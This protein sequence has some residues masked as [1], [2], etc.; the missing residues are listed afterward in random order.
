MG[1]ASANETQHCKKIY[2]RK[3]DVISFYAFLSSAFFSEKI[4]A[5]DRQLKESC[6]SDP[7]CD[8]QRS[9]RDGRSCYLPRQERDGWS[10]GKRETS[11]TA[12]FA[13]GHS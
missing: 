13:H 7:R 10:E 5:L 1:N 2:A 11:E 8:D 6:Y 12:V 9:I 3:N 4:W